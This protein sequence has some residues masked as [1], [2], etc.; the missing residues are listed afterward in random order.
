MTT[1]TH[2]AF[3]LLRAALVLAGCSLLDAR[4]AAAEAC[5]LGNPIGVYRAMRASVISRRRRM[6]ELRALYAS[7]EWQAVFRAACLVP[8]AE[9]LRAEV[10]RMRSS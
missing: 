9:A 1:A 7:P 2:M 5:F 4:D 3:Y 6:R 8:A 10:E